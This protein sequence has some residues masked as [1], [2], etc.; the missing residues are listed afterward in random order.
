MSNASGVFVIDATQLNLTEQEAAA[1]SEAI[2][3]TVMTEI[4]KLDRSRPRSIDID[5]IPDPLVAARSL[6]GM[7][8]MRIGD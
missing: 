8:G 5:A 7:A 2:A 1:I 4:G 6:G 3:K